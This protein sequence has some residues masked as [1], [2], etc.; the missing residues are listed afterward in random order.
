MPIEQ[1]LSP[2]H[3]S[4][5]TCRLSRLCGTML[6]IAAWLPVHADEEGSIV[7]SL[8]EANQTIQSMSCEVRRES[9][10]QGRTVS[11]LSR[12]HFARG[13]RLLVETEFP[14]PRRILVDG[15][16]IYKWIEGQASGVRVPVDDAPAGEIVQLRRV[17]GT[18]EEFLLRLQGVQEQ[19]LPSQAGLPVRRGYAPAAPHPYAV[20]ALDAQGQL[21]RVEFFDS[22]TR[23]VRLLTAEFSAWREVAPGCWLAQTQKMKTYAQNGVESEEI[24]RVS[25]IVV[26]QPIDTVSFDIAQQAA[27][28]SFMDRK[29]MAEA[30]SAPS[31]TS[32]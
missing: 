10:A 2:R 6:V 21:A 28:V 18:G 7:N 32:K 27:G 12:V 20:V 14:Q 17:P 16:T 9:R 15:S 29:S 30:L 11:T 25:R 23:D 22:T 3:N 1:I 5:L 8:L 4:S 13:D 24:V 31:A 19:H 26:N